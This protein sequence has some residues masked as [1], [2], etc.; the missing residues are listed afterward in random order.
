MKSIKLVDYIELTIKQTDGAIKTIKTT[1]KYMD[2]VNFKI[3]QKNTFEANGRKVLSYKKIMKEGNVFSSKSE[4]YRA[5]NDTTVEDMSR[6]G[7]C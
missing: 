2:E 5:S 6:M 4:Y 7:D 1:L 3:I